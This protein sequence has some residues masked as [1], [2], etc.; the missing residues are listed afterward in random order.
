MA[1]SETASEVGDLRRPA[2]LVAAARD[3]RREPHD[4][5]GLGVEVLEL[6]ADVNMDAEHVETAIER[7]PTTARAW[8]GGRPN[9][10]PWWPVLIAS[11]V[12]AS[13]P[14]VTR[15]RT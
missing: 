5:L 13:T 3:E 15:T 6:R 8:S 10:E 12:S 7:S 2:E 14:S 11:C 9:F 1:D 4:R